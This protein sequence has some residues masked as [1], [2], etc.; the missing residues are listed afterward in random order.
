MVAVAYTVPYLCNFNKCKV[1]D[2][3]AFVRKYSRPVKLVSIM[4]H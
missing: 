4:Y 1:K 3:K 2:N